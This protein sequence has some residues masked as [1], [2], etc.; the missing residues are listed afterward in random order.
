MSH[1]PRSPDLPFERDTRGVATD[2]VRSVLRT[3]RI[4]SFWAAIVLPITYLPLLA[5]GLAGGEAVPFAALVA[6]NA[7]AFVLGH[8]H[9]PADAAS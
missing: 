2:A 3:L 7:G 5:G 6:L 9:D 1:V 8:D 4:A